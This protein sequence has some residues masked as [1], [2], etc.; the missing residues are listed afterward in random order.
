MNRRV[1]GPGVGLIAMVTVALSS[2]G[3]AGT[4]TAAPAA[5]SSPPAAPTG[6]AGATGTVAAVTTSD[7][8]VQNP[9]I[10]QVR[11][12]FS[13]STS[14]TTTVSATPG[15]LIVGDCALATGAPQPT[16][17]P[18]SPL[19]AT[20][21]QISQAAADGSCGAGGP[22]RNARAGGAGGGG[23]GGGGPGGTAP[24]RS[25]NGPAPAGRAR[26]AAALGK[27]TSVSQD[28]FVI[29]LGT[30]NTGRSV[31]TTQT[32]TFSKTVPT[33]KSGLAVG[34]CVTAIGPSDDTGTVAAASISIRPPGPNG[35]QGGFGGRGR[36]G[37]SP[38]TGGG[39][40]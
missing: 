13:P 27:V 15:D 24:P 35:C 19:T 10:G 37:G 1:L 18:T 33:D 39:G 23:P 17:D 25:P 9:R 6:P 40:T 16:G 4:T 20:S 21:V 8:Q 31:T 32:T 7:I 34:K 3:G 14:F 38:A 5:E 36:A 29:Q 11:V 12:T 2:C 26:G 28:G 22:G 30:S